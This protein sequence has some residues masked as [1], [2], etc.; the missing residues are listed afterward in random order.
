MTI[1]PRVIII[2]GPN[3][4]ANFRDWYAPT[5]DAWVLYDNSFSEPVALDW[6]IR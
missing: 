6:S 1:Q 3:G 2:A 4:A 5:V